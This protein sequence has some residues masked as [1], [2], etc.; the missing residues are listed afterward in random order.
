MRQSHLAKDDTLPDRHA[1]VQCR[2]G[3]VLCRFTI[4]FQ[5]ELFDRV[6]G[7]FLFFEEDLVG[8]GCGAVG[9]ILGVVVECRGEEDDLSSSRKLSVDALAQLKHHVKVEITVGCG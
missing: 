9:E 5:V 6:D 4:A 2:Q 3:V 8:L 7:H 1:V